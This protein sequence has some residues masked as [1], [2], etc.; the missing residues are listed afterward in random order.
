LNITF[1]FNITIAG[2]FCYTNSAMHWK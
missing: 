2:T 1:D